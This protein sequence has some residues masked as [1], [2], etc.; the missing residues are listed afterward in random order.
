M[1]CATMRGGVRASLIALTAVL[2][3]S[4]LH[5]AG[6]P[7]FTG[8]AQAQPPLSVGPSL[9]KA[10]AAY[11]LPDLA[12]IE[13]QFEALARRVS[14]AVVAI[15]GADTAS[16]EDASNRADDLNSD[17]LGKMLDTVD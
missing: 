14:P 5:A 12:A 3:Y 15:S 10:P 2:G 1:G 17:R 11:S 4:L 16:P 13:R 9:P 8:S 6:L 7:S